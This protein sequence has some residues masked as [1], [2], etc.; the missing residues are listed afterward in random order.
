MK[1]IQVKTKTGT[2]LDIEFPDSFSCHELENAFAKAYL[3][4]RN[5]LASF[6]V[7]I[8]SIGSQGAYEAMMGGLMERKDNPNW[9]EFVGIACEWLTPDSWA[10]AVLRARAGIMGVS[11]QEVYEKASIEIEGENPKLSKRLK[12]L[13]EILKNIED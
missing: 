10:L 5:G 13:V 3:K 11:V 8:S 4:A 6:S 2:I 12:E 9:K 1:I 7:D